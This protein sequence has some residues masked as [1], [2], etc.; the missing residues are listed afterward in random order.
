MIKRI[1]G[2]GD[3]WIHGD[4]LCLPPGDKNFHEW[5]PSFEK[6]RRLY[7]EKNCILGQ[8]GTL[9]NCSVENYG[10]S[11]ASLQCTMWEFS[12]WL[13]MQT[14]LDQNTLIFVGLTE[15]SRQSWWREIDNKVNY[16]HN[17]AISDKKWN[18]FVKFYEVHSNTESLWH[19]NYQIATEFFAGV[20]KNNNLPLAMFNI[21]AQ[22]S[23]NKNVLDSSWNM[24]GYLSQLENSLGNVTA[25]CFHP[26][27]K[28]CQLLSK[29][30][31]ER[32]KHY[33]IV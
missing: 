21:F 27:E 3:S 28:G 10:I 4:G 2:F 18:D 25:P 8:L 30:L 6:P 17:H 16:I 5:E 12:R 11:G 9:L 1:V 13:E 14:A 29:H 23:H 26:N 19:M 20:C 7:R 24:R 22:N 32:L 31:L 33:K 15:S